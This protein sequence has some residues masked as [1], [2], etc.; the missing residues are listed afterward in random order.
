M[1]EKEVW[2]EARIGLRIFPSRIRPPMRWHNWA[3]NF[4]STEMTPSKLAPPPLPWLPH[5]AVIHH[6][7]MHLLPKLEYFWLR[8]RFMASILEQKLRWFLGNSD[9]QIK[10]TL[11]LQLVVFSAVI[12][13][14]TQSHQHSLEIFMRRGQETLNIHEKNSLLIE[15]HEMEEE[16]VGRQTKCPQFKATVTHCQLRL[17]R[18]RDRANK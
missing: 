15:K 6:G 2:Y 1:T 14:H 16:I 17:A 9:F 11:S 18:K 4:R 13:N 7:T 8:V 5:G 3:D 12:S 10:W